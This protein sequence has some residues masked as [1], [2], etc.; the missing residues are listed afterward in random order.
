MSSLATSFPDLPALT[1]GLAKV[2][3]GNGRTHSASK[4]ARRAMAGAPVKVLHRKPLVPTMTFPTE[5]VTCRTADKGLL[6]LFCKY[7][8]GH[9][10]NAYG[11]RGG[12]AY[13]ASVY[14]EILQPLN[15]STPCFYGSFQNQARHDAWLVLQYVDHGN[16][17]RDITPDLKTRPQP[18]AIGLAAR[19]IGHFHAAMSG[20]ETRSLPAF[21]NI[22]DAQYYNGW[23]RRTH[24]LTKPLHR[25]FPWL[26]KLCKRS[27]ELLAPLLEPPFTVIHGEYYQNN[28]VIRNRTVYPTDWESAAVAAGEIDL[29]ELIE[30]PWAAGLVK[31]CKREYQ[32]ARWPDGSPPGFEQTFQAAQLYLHF[33]WLGERA[34]WTLRE[35]SRWRFQELRSVAGRLGLV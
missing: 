16:L 8:A 30:G 4:G 31:Q 23:I 9:D 35:E 33:R 6:K 28:I 29:A 10:H 12:V 18:T 2:L 17:L 13:E 21:L 3:N 15:S 25:R 34:D 11:H 14:R 32:Q 19:W 26:P 27:G 1:R 20:H 5:I 22:Y 7:G 24:K